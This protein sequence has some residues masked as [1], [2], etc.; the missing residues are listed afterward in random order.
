MFIP[1]CCVGVQ[2]DEVMPLLRM[3]S[4]NKATAAATLD[5]VHTGGCTNLSGG[6]FQGISQQI[7]AC[8]V[9]A[10]SS[11]DAGAP[12]APD[13]SASS[14][15]HAVF[16]LTDGLPNRG[17]CDHDQ[18]AKMLSSMLEDARRMHGVQLR[19][20]TFGFG[21]DADPELL[22]KLAD[23]GGGSYFF[24]ESPEQVPDV[25]GEALGGLLST[26]CQ[27]VEVTITPTPG[28]GVELLAVRSPYK[29]E[30][31]PGGGFKVHIGDMYEEEQKDL[32]VQ[33]KAPSLRLPPPAAD[34]AEGR[35]QQQSLMVINV[36]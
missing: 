13:G 5:R 25:F 34:S 9:D 19:V 7:A 35:Q 18:L 27:N 2:V 23:V 31:M 11:A 29:T 17:V 21:S 8:N 24:I 28:S 1:T 20:S 36:R 26:C 10:P 6:L 4:T 32:V 14:S 22:G 33:L 12:A 3:S 30:A 16:L 15:T